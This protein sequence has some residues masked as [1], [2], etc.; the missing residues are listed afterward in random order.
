[1]L[2]AAPARPN[3]S[4]WARYACPSGCFWRAFV[5][6]PAPTSRRNEYALAL[7]RLDRG[8]LFAARAADVCTGRCWLFEGSKLTKVAVRGPYRQSNY[9]LKC[10]PIGVLAFL[11]ERVTVKVTVIRTMLPQNFQIFGR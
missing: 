6:L 5:L 9:W 10:L 2:M 3:R 11:M 1:M 7:V 8:H 4:T